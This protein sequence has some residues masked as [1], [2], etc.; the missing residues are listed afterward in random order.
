MS[1][2]CDWVYF[3]SNGGE[4]EVVFVE[5]LSRRVGYFSISLVLC[6]IFIVV[7]VFS[8]NIYIIGMIYV[9]R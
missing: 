6:V 1:R 8:F 4:G 9:S 3:F 2:I 7:C 5:D